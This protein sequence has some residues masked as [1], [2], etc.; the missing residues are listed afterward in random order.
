MPELVA[1]QLPA[2]LAELEASYGQTN[3]A[4]AADDGDMTD[5]ERTWGLAPPREYAA[6]LATTLD[7]EYRPR[8]AAR[9]IAISSTAG[10]PAAAPSIIRAP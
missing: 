7:K 3:P 9:G 10:A 2:M 6:I 5:A 8:F 4:I 1:G